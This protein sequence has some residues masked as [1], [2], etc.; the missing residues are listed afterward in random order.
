MLLSVHRMK[1]TDQSTQG[2]L[3]INGVME[4][5]TLEPRHDRSQGKPYC[6]PAGLYD[7]SIFSSPRF[8]R[9]VIR[10]Q[11]VPGF[12]DI[13]VHPGN[14]PRDTHGCCLVGRTEGVDFV[15]HSDDA[16]DELIGKITPVGQ[17]EYIDEPETQSTVIQPPLET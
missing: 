1:Y 2:M 5:Y 10:V 9:N 7:Y 15:G 14:Y 13:E 4:C 11:D 17:I 16:F 8:G 6:V 12:E 3:A